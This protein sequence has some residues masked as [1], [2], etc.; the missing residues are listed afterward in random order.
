MFFFSSF[1]RSPGVVLF[2]GAMARMIR[3]EHDTIMRNQYE[4]NKRIILATQT[5]CAI[6]GGIVDKTK[7]SPDPLSPSVDHIIPIAKGGNPIDM[8]NLQLT[9][10]ACNRAKG[11]RILVGSAPEKKPPLPQSMD[12]RTA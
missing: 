2:G 1:G 6:C 9:H 10:R 12:W 3:P 7:K 4:A 8:S 11:T 5:T